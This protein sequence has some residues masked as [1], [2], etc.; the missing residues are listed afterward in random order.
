MQDPSD[1]IESAE[2]EENSQGDVDA[3]DSASATTSTVLAEVLPGV[4]VVFGEVPA[5]LELDLIDFGL[6]PAADRKEISA[7]WTSS[8]PYWPNPW[9]SRT[10]NARHSDG[11]RDHGR[12]TR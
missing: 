9:R 1:A 12:P 3:E 7:E 4:A 10:S 8:P 5:E 2:L 11:N 6:V